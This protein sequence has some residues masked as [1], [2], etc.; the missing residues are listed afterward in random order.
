MYRQLAVYIIPAVFFCSL[1]ALLSENQAP[2]PNE[3]RIGALLCLTGECAEWGTNSLDGIRLAVEEINNSG[4]LL[5][6]KLAVDVQDSGEGESAG[7]AVSALRSFGKM[8]EGRFIIGPSWTPAGLAIAPVA[9]KE[10]GLIL[11][12]PSLGVEDFNETA[13]NIFNIWPHDSIATRKLAEFAY[14]LGLRRVGIFSSEQPWE[15][16]QGQTFA[17]EFERLG[18]IV[19]ALVEPLPSEKNLKTEV[20]KLLA[21]QP[22]FIFFANFGQMGVAAKELARAQYSGRKFAILMDETQIKVAQGALEDVIY[23]GYPDASAEFQKKYQQRYGK[24]PGITADTGYDAVHLYVQAILQAG[25]FEQSKI[26][27]RLQR[28]VFDGASGRIIFDAE[29]G[30]KKAPVLY[31]V[32]QGEMEL[33]Q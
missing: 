17:K 31:Q 10:K 6:R 29:G 27:T 8:P 28:L 33:L 7:K 20:L 24:Q 22:E 21:K 25:S 30:V 26:Q 5:G 3:L 12:S 15:M 18:G 9:A 14:E 11:M 1:L 13:D 16:K 23:A 19:L 4:G 32:R 2:K